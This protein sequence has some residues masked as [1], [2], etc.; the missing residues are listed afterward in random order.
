MDLAHL[1]NLTEEDMT[2]PVYGC[3]ELFVQAI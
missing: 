2:D 3:F 1:S